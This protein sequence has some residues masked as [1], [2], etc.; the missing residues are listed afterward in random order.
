MGQLHRYSCQ[1]CGSYITVDVPDAQ[2]GYVGDSFCDKV[3][4]GQCGDMGTKIYC[5]MA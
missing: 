4:C 5:G 3:T 1:K 2:L